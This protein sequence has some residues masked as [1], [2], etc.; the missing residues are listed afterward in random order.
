MFSQGVTCHITGA[1]L[2]KIAAGGQFGSMFCALDVHL[3]CV[4]S[5]FVGGGGFV[6]PLDLQKNCGMINGCAQKLKFS[7]NSTLLATHE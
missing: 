6:C 4:S 2:F 7:F 5:Y 3:R 1:F